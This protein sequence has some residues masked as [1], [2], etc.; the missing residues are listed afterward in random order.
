M[1][2]PGKKVLVS[3]CDTLNLLIGNDVRSRLVRV[4]VLFLNC[5]MHELGG[6]NIQPPEEQDNMQTKT[7]GLKGTQKQF[8][9]ISSKRSAAYPE[10]IGEANNNNN[11]KT[12]KA[13]NKE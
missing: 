4:S 9:N 6:L 13:A 12:N 2:G 7:S 8:N 11:N 10:K 3:L 1:S 5:H